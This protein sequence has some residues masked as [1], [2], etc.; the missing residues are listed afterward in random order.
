MGYYSVKVYVP[1][2]VYQWTDEDKDT[3]GQGFLPFY[4]SYSEAIDNFP[5][6]NIVA[7]DVKLYEPPKIVF[8]FNLN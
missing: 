3:I 8:N 5:E 7:L 1:I 4:F 6:S 2:I